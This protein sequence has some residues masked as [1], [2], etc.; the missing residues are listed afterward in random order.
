MAL[1]FMQPVKRR[2]GKSTEDDPAVSKKRRRCRVSDEEYER[3]RL[4]KLMHQPPPP[5]P[6]QD[7]AARPA[8]DVVIATPAVQP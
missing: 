3:L 4:A 2:R 8:R 5:A 1:E 6:S 7:Q